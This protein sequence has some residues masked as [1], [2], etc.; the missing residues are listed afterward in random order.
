MNEINYIP[1]K[2]VAMETVGTADVMNNIEQGIVCAYDGINN[3]KAQVI[4][5]KAYIDECKYTFSKKNID[6]NGYYTLPGGLIIQW[7]TRSVDS[8]QTTYDE[9]FDFPLRF[10]TCCLNLN[11]MPFGGDDNWDSYCSGHALDA[12]RAR[13]ILRGN[14]ASFANK[15]F[16]IAIGM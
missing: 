9:I 5:N 1:T 4:K 3:V 12:S 7:G 10:P 14:N 2:W 11:A 6:S 13:I 15:I 16:W 8:G